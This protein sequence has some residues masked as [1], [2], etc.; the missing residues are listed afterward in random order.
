MRRAATIAALLCAMMLLTGGRVSNTQFR[1]PKVVS[2]EQFLHARAKHYGIPDSVAHGVIRAE[3]SWDVKARGKAGE[4]GLMQVSLATAQEITRNPRLTRKDLR[5]PFLN[6]ELGLFY[7][8]AM[9]QKFGGNMKLALAAYNQGP[10]KVIRTRQAGEK[11]SMGYAGKVLRYAVQAKQTGL[12]V[13]VTI[14]G[15]FPMGVI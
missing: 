6:V 8:A 12:K 4:T 10:G 9:R 5:D 15:T 2:F 7:L 1:N 11:V 14:Y 13:P 3:S